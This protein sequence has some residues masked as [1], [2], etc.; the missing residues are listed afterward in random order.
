MLGALQLPAH[1]FT[2]QGFEYWGRISALKA[3]IV[4]ADKVSTVSP[5]YAE[6]LMTPEFGMGMEGVLASRGGDFVG[7]LNGIDLEAWTPPFADLEGKA[8]RPRRAARRIRP[9]RGGRPALRR[10]LAPVRTKGAGPA[11]RG[12]AGADRK[13]RPADRA[14]RGRCRASRRRCAM[15]PNATRPMSRCASAMTRRWRIA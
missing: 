8:K 11:D 1:L 7:I 10:H 4:F 13:W 12:A 6:E 15:R 3:G 9:A 2:P 5:T 14:G